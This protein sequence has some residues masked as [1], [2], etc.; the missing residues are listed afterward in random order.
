MASNEKK[1]K[2]RSPFGLFM[3]KM[4]FQNNNLR[5][6]SFDKVVKAC[7]QLYKKLSADQKK[8]FEKL[9]Q[10][11]RNCGLNDKQINDCL[12]KLNIDSDIIDTNDENWDNCDHNSDSDNNQKLVNDCERV[13]QSIKRLEDVRNASIIVISF[14]ILVKTIEGVYYPNEI[15]LTKFTLNDGIQRTYH[16]LIYNQIPDGYYATAKEFARMTH[17]IPLNPNPSQPFESNYKLLFNHIFEFMASSDLIDDK[18]K[19]LVFCKPVD[20]KS[21]KADKPQVVGCL[22]WLQKEAKKANQA[23]D[24]DF[25]GFQVI[26]LTELLYA[27]MRGIVSQIMPKNAFSDHLSKCIYDYL[28]KISC[29]YHDSK[30]NNYCSLGV[31]KRLSYLFFDLSLDG[32]KIKAKDNHKPVQQIK[33]SVES[34]DIDFGELKINSN[35]KDSHKPVEQNEES[36]EKLD[37]K[38]GKLN[39]NSSAKEVC[40]DLNL[41]KTDEQKVEPIIK[42]SGTYDL[43]KPYVIG[44]GR[45]IRK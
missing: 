30:E 23:L 18:N 31:T 19:K 39:I 17:E 36:I 21:G 32:L 20:N 3:R 28:P 5:Q 27:I 24:K 9:S 42:T 2:N 29:D 40:F 12:R 35:A 25:S 11:I 41:N 1:A 43:R 8:P 44:I 10:R 34:F 22:E 14:N 6:Q 45:G 4:S 13:D 33:D 7:D 15:G 16:K 37:N 38:F 26:D